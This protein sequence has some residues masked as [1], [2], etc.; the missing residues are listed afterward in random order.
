MIMMVELKFANSSTFVIQLVH[1]TVS[2]TSPQRRFIFLPF[3]TPRM[4]PVISR[5]I[6]M[7]FVSYTKDRYPSLP[8][9][10]TFRTCH[11]VIKVI[12]FPSPLRDDLQY[13]LLVLAR[14]CWQRLT[15]A[16]NALP[17]GFPRRGGDA[18]VRRT[19]LDGNWTP[20]NQPAVSSSPSSCCGSS[21]CDAAPP[22][23][24][25]ASDPPHPGTRSTA[26]LSVDANRKTAIVASVSGRARVGLQDR[27]FP[28]EPSGRCCCCC[29]CCSW[30]AESRLSSSLMRNSL[31]SK[32]STLWA[33]DCGKGKAEGSSP[34]R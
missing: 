8:G 32:G 1:N 10:T 31:M 14:R 17:S 11:A 21:C 29:C 22:R 28:S 25:A 19:S 3:R 9:P 4:P 33:A 24:A 2:H 15:T 13:E 12:C 27:I 16:T 6:P 30:A 5:Q 26:C 23:S 20:W 18:N 7:T 34:A